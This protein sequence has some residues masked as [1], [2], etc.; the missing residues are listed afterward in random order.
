MYPNWGESPISVQYTWEPTIYK[1][2]NGVEAEDVFAFFEPETYGE[3]QNTYRVYGTYTK[4]GDKT[5]HSAFLRFNSDGEMMEMYLYSGDDSGTLHQVKPAKGDTF[6]PDEE[7]LEFKDNPDG[8]SN[9]YYGSPIVFSKDGAL[10]MQAYYGSA[11]K[12]ALSI[13]AEDMDGN[14]VREWGTLEVTE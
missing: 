1:L 2:S 13:D 12:Y 4:S 11:G 3:E 14:T 10:S 5:E 7:W 9:T 6:I 8:E